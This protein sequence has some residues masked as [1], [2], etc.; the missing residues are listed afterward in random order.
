MPTTQTKLK[1]CRQNQLHR[2]LVLY[3]HPYCTP[4]Q[5]PAS[6]QLGKCRKNKP[7]S[8]HTTILSSPIPS[9]RVYIH[10]YYFRCLRCLC[11]AVP[12]VVTPALDCCLENFDGGSKTAGSSDAITSGY[13]AAITALL[14]AVR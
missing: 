11:I 3:F 1:Q 6:R 7:Q 13:S 12:S 4:A 5:L 10:I 2:S 14:G 9:L 8:F